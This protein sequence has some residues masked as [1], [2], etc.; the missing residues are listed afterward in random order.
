[1]PSR[2][3][4]A[5]GAGRVG[6]PGD[7]WTALLL[8][9][10]AGDQEALDLVLGAALPRL[11]RLARAALHNDADSWDVAQSAVLRVLRRLPSFR[12]TPAGAWAY[13]ARIAR[14]LAIDVLR[15][16]ARQRR[17]TA[18]LD[19]DEV[20]AP[21][22]GPAWEA[23]ASEER[24]AVRR[25]LLRARADYRR[26]VVLRYYE[27]KSFREIAGDL[28]APPGTAATWVARGLRELRNHLR[29]QAPRRTA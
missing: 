29:A 8:R 20:P 2:T 13:L 27:G 26:A 14:R 11:H 24:A 22:R 1:M 12:A 15:S 9:G 5:D 21:G 3:K 19:P 18:A 23:A 25:A 10:Q 4:P 6:P 28:A 16:R 7:E 17:R